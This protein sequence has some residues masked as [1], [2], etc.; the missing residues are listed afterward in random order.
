MRQLATAGIPKYDNNAKKNKNKYPK[1]NNLGMNGHW[2]MDNWTYR[3]WLTV[4]TWLTTMLI[5]VN[6]RVRP[7]STRWE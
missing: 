3:S 2:T 1:K 6:S 4:V 5:M 7:I